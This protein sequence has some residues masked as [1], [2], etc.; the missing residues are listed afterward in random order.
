MKMPTNDTPVLAILAGGGSLPALV[1]G[2]ALA[3]GFEVQVVTFD[4]QAA[5]RGLPEGVAGQASFNIAAVGKIL[6]HL[7]AHKVSH[8]VMAGALHKPSLF[9]LRPD[10]KGVQL[11]ARV[12]GFHDDALLRGV[13]GFLADE[14]FTV[15]PVTDL[16]PALAAKDGVWGKYAPSEADKADIALGMEVL[17]AMGGLDIGQAVV[18]HRGTVLGVE[19]VEGTDGL[20]ARCA[21]LRGPLG[22]QERAGWLIKAAKPSQ[23]DLADLPTIGPATVELLALHGYKGVAVQAGKTLVVDGE[24]VVA[25]ADGHGV[26]GVGV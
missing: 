23:T 10:V 19:A 7:K 8:V 22:K 24:K 1:A 26:V 5:P 20:I 16:L 4:G 13:A 17:R 3:Q 9:R 21:A 15:L 12:K 6:A 25:V 2:A 18:V 11:L 14:G